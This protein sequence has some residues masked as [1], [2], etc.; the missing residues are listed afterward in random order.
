MKVFHE[1][2]ADGTCETGSASTPVSEKSSTKVREN[3]AAQREVR[4]MDKLNADLEKE[5]KEEEAEKTRKNV[6]DSSEDSDW[7]PSVYGHSKN[8]LKK[9]GRPRG[10]PKSRGTTPR[11]RQGGRRWIRV[12]ICDTV[13]EIV[14]KDGYCPRRV[15]GARQMHFDWKAQP[16]KN[17]FDLKTV[18][19]PP[20]PIPF[21]PDIL[22]VFLCANVEGD[23][24][25]PPLIVYP[26]PPSPEVKAANPSL[27]WETHPEA[28]VTLEVYSKWLETHFAPAV[29][30]YCRENKLEEKVLLL[31]HPRLLD[32]LLPPPPT[33]IKVTRLGPYSTHPFEQGVADAIQSHYN[34]NLM[35]QYY[36]LLF[37]NEPEKVLRDFWTTCDLKKAITSL[38]K[39]WKDVSQRILQDAWQ[40]EWPEG[41]PPLPPPPPKSVKKKAAPQKKKPKPSSTSRKRPPPLSRSS[42]SH[43]NTASHTTELD[44]LSI[45]PHTST[46]TTFH[47][48]DNQLNPLFPTSDTLTDTASPHTVEL[49]PLSLTPHT[50]T[51]SYNT[52]S[53]PTDPPSQ[54][55]DVKPT[56]SSLLP[57]GSFQVPQEVERLLMKATRL[58]L[59]K[60]PDLGRSTKLCLGVMKALMAWTDQQQT[61]PSH[62]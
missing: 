59:E 43:T 48:T 37:R 55:P 57:A 62:L 11:G 41:V 14:E 60:D 10:R 8:R 35:S 5:E 56:I 24:R 34:M 1:R 40:K 46:T 19:H 51:Y 3:I 53:M 30:E 20:V 27:V 9:R 33:A 18:H 21:P 15:F 26:S 42:C 45:T 17:C 52:P 22:T 61:P 54:M 47:A 31:V 44:P 50:S 28:N 25:L 38:S 4:E 13:Q 39:I 2:N 6:R 12:K 29:T 16:M 36:K 23:M 58:A 49:D 32:P 7:D